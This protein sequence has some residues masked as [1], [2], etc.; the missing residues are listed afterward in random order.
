LVSKNLDWSVDAITSM[1]PI[2]AQV[3]S[4]TPSLASKLFSG[5]CEISV[6]CSQCSESLYALV[7]AYGDISLNYL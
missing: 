1:W 5:S 7:G 4:F 6:S 2:F 3:P